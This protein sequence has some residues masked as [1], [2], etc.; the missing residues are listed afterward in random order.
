VIVVI[1]NSIAG[2]I[3]IN[4]RQTGSISDTYAT[5]IAPAGYVFSIW[6]VIYLLL[7][8]YVAYQVSAKR[9]DSL[10]Q[11]KIGYLFI[12]SCIVNICWLLLWHYEM[13]AASVILM[14]VLFASLLLIYTRLGIG[15]MKV[16]RNE[17]LF[18]HLP[19]SVYLGWITVATI[20]NVAAALVSLGQTE[21]VLGAANW[22]ILV[23]AVAV[24]I[25]GMMLWTRRDIAYAA[26]LIWALI[27]VYVKQS[28]LTPQVSYAALIGA[29][30]IVLFAV[31][32]TLRVQ[33][34]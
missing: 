25:T 30:I 16:E 5:L 2:A 26:V 21:L 23:I 8:G 22:T 11:S 17:W 33:K 34:K 12:A 6:G 1:V 20:A 10:F 13:I 27:G 18:V 31:Y 24:L 29:A 3:G 4:G 32:F 7:L 9:K 14:L 15:V 28:S 19:F